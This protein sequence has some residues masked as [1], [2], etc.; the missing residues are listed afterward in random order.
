MS[1]FKPGDGVICAGRMGYVVSVDGEWAW[2]RSDPKT[3][4]VV[5][6]LSLLQPAPFDQAKVEGAFARARAIMAN[7]M[8]GRND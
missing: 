6:S 5:L 1:G 3:S 7:V 2:V 4:G 8:D